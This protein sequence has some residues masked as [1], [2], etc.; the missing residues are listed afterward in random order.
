MRAAVVVVAV[1]L[2]APALAQDD[3]PPDD[4]VNLG[5]DEELD[6]RLET[7]FELIRRKDVARARACL[8]E[9]SAS[10]GTTAG[11]RAASARRVFRLT[12]DEKREG[13]FA[14]GRLELT[15]IGGLFGVWNGV[16]AGLSISSS[17]RL[18]D[19]P[20]ILLTGG[21]AVGLGVGYGYGGYALADG[22][23]LTGGDAR[24]V[25]SGI[26]WGTIAGGWLAPTVGEIAGN[27]EHFLTF[28][29]MTT[30]ATGWVGAGAALTL[31]TTGDL[32]EGHVSFINTGGWIG[33]FLG[34]MSL[35]TMTA[36]TNQLSPVAFSTGMIL[37][38]A[39][40]LGVGAWIG[41]DLG[42]TWVEVLLVDLGAVL[43]LV[44]S[45]TIALAAL[46]GGLD[47]LPDEIGT[48]IV[49]GT[50]AAGVVGGAVTATLILK[51]LQARRGDLPDVALRP[52]V[53]PTLLVDEEQEAAPALTLAF[54]W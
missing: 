28:A 50:V 1:T 14:P 6:A 11:L 10:E 16:A 5:V 34:G 3:P 45:G 43:G 42:F 41:K 31:A 44:T 40:G 35:I 52:R 48:P 27:S 19:T 54:T 24:L 51:R 8:D 4:V 7:C 29:L 47:N 2:S 17:N 30:V 49:T 32:S 23:G 46:V 21:L 13:V 9:V 15:S 18:G 38:N 26:I 20:S 25:S 22:L 12:L 33:T 36:F 37:G 53:A 39:L